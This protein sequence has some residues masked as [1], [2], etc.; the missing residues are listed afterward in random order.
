[1]GRR[2]AGGSFGGAQGPLRRGL[3][4]SWAPEPG[5]SV[6]VATSQGVLWSRQGEGGERGLWGAA[7]QGAEWLG[8]QSDLDGEGPG[9]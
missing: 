6:N 7:S 4:L 1:M 3:S 9:S 2:A 8:F 5:S